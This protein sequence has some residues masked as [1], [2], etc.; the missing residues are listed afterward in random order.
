MTHSLRSSNENSISGSPEVEF[1]RSAGGFFVAR[2]GDTA[3]AMLPASNGRYYL[4][5]G[6]RIRRPLAQWTRS[7]FY[8]H[9]GQLA[10]EAAFRAK[11][12]EQAEHAREKR[13]LARQ[14]VRSTA[15]T[16]WGPSQGATVFA[17]GVTCHST[18]SHG[19]FHLSPERNCKVDARLR[20]AD[21]FY[22]EDECWAIVAFTFPDLFTSFERRSAERIIKDSFPDAWEEITGNVLAAGQSREKDRR[23]FEAEH[24]ADWIVVS[25]IRADYKKSFVE[26]I[27]TPGGRRGVGSDERRFLVPA[28]EYVIGRFGFVIDHDRHV[29]YGGPSSFAGWQ[30]R[31]RS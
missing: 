25:A 24:A 16:P 13:A 5:T 15:Q 26:V 23:A 31:R 27:A 14:E 11:V 29:V 21:G 19:G 9:C 18:A 3:F 10:D 30:G 6:W 7:D 1:G 12:L 8:G 20:A 28:D 4:A 17:D 22:E 2:A